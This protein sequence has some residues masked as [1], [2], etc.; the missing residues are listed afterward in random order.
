M[1]YSS[2]DVWRSTTIRFLSLSKLRH[3]SQ[4]H[5]MTVF[6]PGTIIRRS[7]L[8]SGVVSRAGTGTYDHLEV[9]LDENELAPWEWRICIKS[10]PLPEN[11]P[12]SS[13]FSKTEGGSDTQDHMDSATEERQFFQ[14]TGQIR[15]YI[16]SDSQSQD[17]WSKLRPRHIKSFFKGGAWRASQEI[18]DLART[19]VWEARQREKRRHEEEHDTTQMQGSGPSA[20]IF[21]R[22][23]SSSGKAESESYVYVI[24]IHNGQTTDSPKATLFEEHETRLKSMLVEQIVNQDGLTEDTDSGYYEGS[25]PS[26]GTTTPRSDTSSTGSRTPTMPSTPTRSSTPNYSPIGL[27]NRSPVSW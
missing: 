5:S 6:R 7:L 3:I 16:H 20:T 21:G 26:S 27:H 24:D 25:L 14:E 22:C 11:V 9:H 18:C 1:I 12:C 23:C 4:Y 19:E 13:T 8:L 15:C 10:T 2:I 17:S